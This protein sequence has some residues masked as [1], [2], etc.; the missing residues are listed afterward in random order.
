MKT[1]SQ[2]HEKEWK[3]RV[4]VLILRYTINKP[5]K[6]NEQDR[7][8]NNNDIFL[9]GLRVITIEK[10]PFYINGIITS[11][12]CDIYSRYSFRIHRP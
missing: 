6:S 8:A 1:A 5:I 2:T 10:L 3:C 12:A 9:Y 11:I 7:S 4:Y